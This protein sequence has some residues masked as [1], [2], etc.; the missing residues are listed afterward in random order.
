MSFAAGFQL[1][2]RMVAEFDEAKRQKVLDERAAKEF[3]RKEQE[4][5][6]ADV[7]RARVDE[8]FGAYNDLQSSGQAVTGNTSGF[9]DPSARMLYGQGSQQAVDDAASYANVES[10]R[11]GLP[12]THTTS[13][14]PDAGGPPAPTVQMRKATE[15]DR[16]GALEKLAVARR[17]VGSM[18]RLGG[19]RKLAEEDQ[20]F[21]G[22][23]KEYTGAE[24]QIGGTASYLNTNSK[25]ITMGSPDKDGFVQLSVVRP[26]GRAEFMNLTRQDQAKLYAA[27][28]LMEVNP[29]RAMELMGSVNKEL[30]AA[31]AQENGLTGTLATNTNSVADKRAGLDVQRFNAQTSRMNANT[32]AAAARQRGALDRMGAA[33]YFEGT[34]GKMYAAIPTMGKNGLEFQTVPVSP[35]GVGLRRPGQAAGQKPAKVS[36]AGEKFMVDGRLMVTDGQGGYIDPKGVL[37]ELRGSAL[38]KAGIP[39]EALSQIQWNADGTRVGFAGRAYDVR[40]P[41]EL[42]ALKNDYLRVAGNTV[43]V[44]EANRVDH[45]TS[46]NPRSGFGPDLTGGVPTGMPSI[47]AGPDAWEAYRLQQG[48]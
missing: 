6:R 18:E 21:A 41:K 9:S 28:R 13:S 11:F 23:L 30:A 36:E 8:A 24:D 26:D 43:A 7:D 14:A 42:R 22:A 35:E 33:Q 32:S 12:A 1:G 37:P 39:D 15:L 48:R 29:A 17:D 47:Y 45:H 38:S 46:N 16:I 25:R 27:G 20:L 44:E 2:N 19:Q 5:S 40:D 3:A 10:R 31:V 34:D 4:W